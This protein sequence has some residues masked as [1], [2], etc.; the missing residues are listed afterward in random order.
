MSPRVVV[1][2]QKAFRRIS[3]TSRRK[4]TN[5]S[6]A[7]LKTCWG[8]SVLRLLNHIG[9]HLWHIHCSQ[10]LQFLHLHMRPRAQ[11]LWC[12][13][14]QPHMSGILLRPQLPRLTHGQKPRSSNSARARDQWLRCDVSMPKA[15]GI[16]LSWEMWVR[17]A[18]FWFF[19]VN[20]D[21]ACSRRRSV[22]GCSLQPWTEYR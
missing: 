9:C 17:D 15:S 2:G 21:T 1:Y 8:Q 14:S 20:R 4:S 6:M 10:P 3:R 13:S 7:W 5:G 22:K 12:R 16:Q 19:Y 18:K 11:L